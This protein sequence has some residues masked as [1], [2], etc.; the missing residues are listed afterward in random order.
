MACS[1]AGFLG[2]QGTATG[3]VA[4]ATGGIFNL[5]G[6]ISGRNIDI[7]ERR[8]PGRR[9]LLLLTPP[10]GRFFIRSSDFTRTS[11]TRPRSA[12]ARPTS[13]SSVLGGFSG[14]RR[15]PATATSPIAPARSTPPNTDNPPVSQGLRRHARASPFR[16]P[17]RRAAAIWNRTSTP[18]SFTATNY[19]VIGSGAFTDKNAG[20]DKGHTVGPSTNTVAV[21]LAAGN[22]T[23]FGLQF[24]GYT[25]APG[26]HSP[27]TPGN[28]VSQITPR[29][30]T[31]TGV[32]GIDRVYDQS[33][34][35]GLN[36]AGASLVG[37][38]GGDIVALV[39][40]RRHRHDGRQERRRQ[41]ADRRQL[42]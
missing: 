13:T 10:G 18:T 42:G 9:Q 25:R 1:T 32:D 5:D 38:I 33:P 8:L 22:V 15:P 11:S 14:T 16:K 21:N 39:R 29:P 6:D 17:A 27:G 12:P 40:H 36:I 37:T 41:Q 26:P 20:I 7:T 31:A 2:A 28:P 3:D 35:V 24:A 23:Y 19:S 4:L 34:T 30:I